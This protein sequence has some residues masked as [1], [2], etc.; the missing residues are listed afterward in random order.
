MRVKPIPIAWLLAFVL[1]SGQLAS[2]QTNPLNLRDFGAAGDGMADDGPA[3]QAA[4]DALAAAGG[5]TLFVPAGR[6][7]IITPVAKDFGGASSITILGV[8]SSTPVDNSGDGAELARGLDLVSEFRP[9][10]GATQI[11]L[12]ISG[13]QSFLVHDVAFVGTPDVDTDALI[14]LRL[15]RIA[16]ATIKHC[17]F[18]GLSTEGGAVVASIRS[19]L[20][21]EQRQQQSPRAG[22]RESRVE[23]FLSHKLCFR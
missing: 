22:C 4:L 8:E 1:S 15:D 12:S 14:T 20:S 7:A 9:Q 13:L 19:R 16:S 11:A 17:E 21:I 2:A 23:G 5:G 10:T 18:Y 6:Y 3:L